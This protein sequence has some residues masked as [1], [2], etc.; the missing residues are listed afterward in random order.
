M[1]LVLENTGIDG[2]MTLTTDGLCLLAILF[3]FKEQCTQVYDLMIYVRHI[4]DCIVPIFS[5]SGMKPIGKFT[6]YLHLLAVC[7]RLFMR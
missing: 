5:T 1:F 6:Y 7:Q 2:H 4:R 3:F